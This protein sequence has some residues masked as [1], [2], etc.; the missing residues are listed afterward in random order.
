MESSVQKAAATKAPFYLCFLLF[1]N[2]PLEDQTLP[3]TKITLLI[4][5]LEPKQ[6]L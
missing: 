4:I 1:I 3:K 5:K 6:I 2:V